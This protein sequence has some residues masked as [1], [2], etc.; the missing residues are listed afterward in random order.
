MKSFSILRTNV[1]LTTNVKITIDSSYNMSL[2]SID[3]DYI[4]SSD[5]Y[6]KFRFSINDY[7]DEIISS[8]FKNL[9]SDVAFQINYDNDNDTMSDDFSKQYKEIY[10]YGARNII[11]NKYYEE[12]YE[13]FAPIYIQNSLPNFF[14]VFRVDGPGIELVNSEN[15]KNSILKNIKVVKVFDLTTNTNVGKWLDNNFLSNDNFPDSPMEIYFE[16]LE[17]SRW[18]GIDYENGGYTSKSL[19]LDEVIEKEREIFEL[20]KYVFDNY[21]NTK[22]IFPNILNLSF[23]FNDRPSTPDVERRWSLNRYFGF[24]LNDMDLVTTMSPYKPPLLRS[25][26]EI[27]EGNIIYSSSN[28][29]NPFIED[30]SE[31]KPFYIEVDGDYYLV[32]R[33]SETR[34][35]EIELVD[36]DDFINEEYRE[37]IFFNYKVISD[38][39]LSGLQ[40]KINKNYGYIDSDNILRSENGNLFNISDYDSADVWIIRIDGFYHTIVKD[41][42]NKIKINS[43]YSF[44][45]KE[46][47]FEYK[48]ASIVNTKSIIVDDK[49]P[50][51]KFD[52]FKLNFTDIKDFDTRIVDTEFSKYEYEKKED[53]TLTSEPK[54]YFEKYLKEDDIIEIDN[55]KYKNEDVNIPVSSE[56]TANYETFKI[57]NDELS[58]IWRINP[59]YCRWGY[60]NSLSN[61][62]LPYLLNNSTIFED[63]NK[64]P[65]PLIGSVSRKNRNLDY[66]YTI[67]SSTASYIHHSLHV[68]S[69]NGGG[70]DESFKF[71]LDKY[72]N[73]A[74]QSVGTY[75]VDYNFDY[76]TSFFERPM[77]FDNLN[78]KKNVKKYSYFNKGDQSIP[79]TTVFKGIEFKV[80]NVN[81]IILDQNRKIEKVNVRSLNDFNDYKF[82]II[83]TESPNNMEW[84]IIDEWNPDV[85]YGF[86]DVVLFDDI[87]YKSEIND[88]DTPIN[89]IYWSFF[90]NTSSILWSPDKSYNDI[91]SGTPS[92]VY[93][94]GE[95]YYCDD[96]DSNIDF[97]NP[98]LEYELND[99]VLYKN[100]YYISLKTRNVLNP[101]YEERSNSGLKSSIQS[102]ENWSKIKKPPGVKWKVINLWSPNSQYNSGVYVNH[103][104]VIYVS[105]SDVEIG[106]EPGISILWNRVYSL[107]PESDFIYKPNDNGMLFMNNK[108]YLISS[109]NN[110]ETLDNGINIY[111]NQKWR[112]I[113][114]NIYVNDNT[115]NNLSNRNRDDIYTSFYSI[116]TAKNFIQSINDLS[117][118]YGFT[119]YLNYIVINQDGEISRYNY[120]MDI[121][122]L[123]FIISVDVPTELIMRKDS[124]NKKPIEYDFTTNFKLVNQRIDKVSKI[125][126][127]NNVPIAYSISENKTYNDESRYIKIHR[128]SGYYMPIFYDIEIFNKDNEF[129]E[130]GNYLFDTNLSDFGIMKERKNRKINR[131][132]SLLRLRD[133]KRLRSIFPMIGEFG[134]SFN[135]FMI[136]KSTW[137]YDYHIETFQ[138]KERFVDDVKNK[139]EIPSNIGQP[140]FVKLENNKKYLI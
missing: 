63:Y 106:E 45:F 73:T 64:S 25:D 87:L 53:I 134:Y 111:I 112:N 44:V 19:F 49:N 17:F 116:L 71:E 33:Y 89:S 135:D 40:S 109:N 20:E 110:N 77:Y 5:R 8:F 16:N 76:F 107:F 65:N 131:R 9:P 29:G 103:N 118:R 66:F 46:D 83:L 124:L 39:D 114:V 105:T 140:V 41:N 60:Q 35:D 113:L 138:N 80:Y 117:E 2:N 27:L 70:I 3:S 104:D 59:V 121:E 12:E 137:D 126:W 31:D 115:L 32:K 22:T 102:Y 125:N 14:V 10:N 101:A 98:F 18:N 54:M 4:L 88:N 48:S 96:S 23:L 61:N 92:I 13:Y 132:G 72:L 93:N 1:G 15:F 79:N 95:Y 6:K 58:D 122:S 28:P 38:I 68:E 128:F 21:K 52:I 119:N 139:K 75:S 108:Y 81:S 69:Y 82:S 84:D 56:Y 11:E 7:Y 36:S 99:I 127:Y 47:R 30:W 50:P 42:E 55:F 34:G 85:N 90:N 133:S 91:G 136:F 130:I 74:T 100:S 67:N 129:S 97:W 26:F 24:Y 51:V 57:E 120:E 86:G 78:I 123:P 62:D 43:D 37:T 94:A